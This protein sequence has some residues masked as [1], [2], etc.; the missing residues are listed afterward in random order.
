MPRECVFYLHGYRQHCEVMKALGC[1]PLKR[2]EDER[3]RNS[4]C[5]TSRFRA[6]PLFRQLE[7]SLARANLRLEMPSAA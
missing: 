3:L 7:R 1:G 2:G 5:L 6:C 4:F